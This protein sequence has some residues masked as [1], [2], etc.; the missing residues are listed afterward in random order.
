MQVLYEKFCPDDSVQAILP[1]KIVS[2]ENSVMG[3]LFPR[4][5][6][7]GNFCSWQLGTEIILFR[8]FC[9]RKF[10]AR[11][12]L[13]KENSDPNKILS[14]F[15]LGYEKATRNLCARKL[16]T[17]K[18]K[19]SY[20]KHTSPSQSCKLYQMRSQVMLIVRPRHCYLAYPICR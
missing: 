3:K 18:T 13:S 11:K 5:F 12:I 10:S 7:T 8:K 6:C 14:Y 19:W 2:R 9:T 16:C 20:E 15:I 4:K 1:R 17:E